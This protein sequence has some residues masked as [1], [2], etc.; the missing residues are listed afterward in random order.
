MKAQMVIISYMGGV[1]NVLARG[2]IAE[3]TQDEYD[4]ALD[5]IKQSI[6]DATYMELNGTIIPG[7][8]IRSSCTINLIKLEDEY[9]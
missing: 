9:D 8:F 2:N 4:Q 3:M 7:D 5:A 6:P 1:R